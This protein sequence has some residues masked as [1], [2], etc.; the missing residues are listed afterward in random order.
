MEREE[1]SS[2]SDSGSLKLSEGQ[3]ERIQRNRERAKA[4]RQARRSAKP[5][6]KSP[7]AVAG[8]ASNTGRTSEYVSRQSGTARPSTGRF[9]DTHGGYL[10]DDEQ[11][12]E[13]HSYCVVED[14]GKCIVRSLIYAD[15]D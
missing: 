6:D 5:Y 10:L 13:Q 7:K 1:S 9:T 2:S 15:S 4:L 8:F 14:D 12:S 3:Q 11:S